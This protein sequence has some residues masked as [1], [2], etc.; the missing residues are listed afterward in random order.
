MKWFHNNRPKHR[1]MPGDY[2]VTI[3]RKYE[4]QSAETIDQVPAGLFSD[5]EEWCDE[6]GL[7]KP[8]CHAAFTPM[9]IYPGDSIDFNLKVNLSDGRTAMLYKLRFGGTGHI[10]I[11][12]G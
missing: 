5:V 1:S 4:C 8:N 11:A 9:H 12:I 10:G 6:M 7:E 2:H 3:T